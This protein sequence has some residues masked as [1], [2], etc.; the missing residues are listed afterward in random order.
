VQDSLIHRIPL[1]PNSSRGRF[2][3]DQTAGPEIESQALDWPGLLV[4]A[5]RNQVASVE[6]VALAHHYVGLNAAP[7]PVTIQGLTDGGPSRDVVVK[8]GEMWVLPARQAVS[9]RV[10]HRE[11]YVRVTLDPRYVGTGDGASIEVRRAHGIVS[12]QLRHLLL[13]LAAEAGASTAAGLPFVEVLARAVGHQVA[14]HAGTERPRLEVHRGGLSSVARRRVLEL[15]DQNLDAP[16]SIS[17]MASEAQ[18][19]PA[20]FAHAFKQ[21][22]GAPPH[23][24]L[25]HLRLER[26]RRM[27]AEPGASLSDVALRAGFADQ[28]HFTRL[29]KRHFGMTPGALRRAKG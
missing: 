15:I 8:P 26:A 9:L 28:A 16:L 29:F 13:T 27:L 1:D 10:E 22:L 6:R 21:T 4:E 18:L 7:N 24:Y 3:I 17:R 23:R 5:G 12:P 11:P 14:L 25:M 2:E 19:S 20:H